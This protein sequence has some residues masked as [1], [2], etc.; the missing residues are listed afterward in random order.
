M[1]S[2]IVGTALLVAVALGG[3]AVIAASAPPRPAVL[4]RIQPGLWNLRTVDSPAPVRALCVA[5][6]SVLIQL[7]HPNTACTRFVLDDSASTGTV[8]YTC[9]GAGHGQTT[10]RLET[11]ALIHIDSQGISENAPFNMQI[12]ARRV[13]PC[14]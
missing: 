2:R 10:I 13:G 1:R 5:D 12:E 7:R 3:A 14:H 4:A 11:S 9:P 8:H 6:P